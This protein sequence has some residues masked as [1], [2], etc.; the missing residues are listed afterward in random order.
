MKTDSDNS[1]SLEDFVK[2]SRPRPASFLLLSI[3]FEVLY[4][5]SFLYLLVN[6]LIVYVIYLL[7]GVGLY[8]IQ[9]NLIISYALV[10]LF[11]RLRKR[12]RVN[13]AKRLQHETRAPIMYLRSFYLENTDQ[14]SGRSLKFFEKEHDDEV[15]ASVLKN[16][17]PLIA[18]GRPGDKIPPLGSIRL[19]F[20]DD[21]WQDQV[22]K[23]ITI[24]QLVIIQPGYTEG[25]EWE[26]EE[27][28]NLP[29]EKLVYPFL[30]WDHLTKSS[31]QNRN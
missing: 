2:Y 25:T 11:G 23:L 16:I 19:Y 9:G 15:L 29:P 22:R 31:R 26:M 27:V 7:I 5:P 13:A 8:L 20:K 1:L 18:V 30:A 3:F 12:F 21:E 4:W 10:V 17:G 24:S 28:R 14:D 6:V